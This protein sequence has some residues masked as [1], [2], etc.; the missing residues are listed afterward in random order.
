VEQIW[1]ELFL[2][3]TNG[4]YNDRMDAINLDTNVRQ[5]L[6]W[7]IQTAPE[8][9]A[10]RARLILAYADGMQTC[11][12]AE[13]AGLSRGR[14]RYWK[15]EF[16]QRGMSIFATGSD[17]WGYSPTSDEAGIDRPK[18]EEKIQPDI[19]IAGRTP[20]GEKR[21]KK[22]HSSK[23]E[24]TSEIP[25]LPFPEPLKNPGLQMNDS[26]VAAGKKIFRLQFAEMLLHEEGS[27]SGEDI[28]ALHDM[29]VASRRLR[30]AFDI[31]EQAFKG[32]TV[33]Q[34]LGG[35][36]RAGRLLGDVRDL[37]V[38]MKNA[39]D[40]LN[41]VSP[42]ERQGLAPLLEAWGTQLLDARERLITHF[43]SDDYHHFTLRFNYFIQT[44]EDGI[45]TFHMDAPVPR[46]ICEIVPILIYTRLASVRAYASLVPNATIPQLHTLRIELKKFRYT[47]EFFTEVLGG[48]A[49]QV[50]D[51]IKKLQDHL[52]DLHDADV[53]CQILNAFL[54][55]WDGSQARV[56]VTERKNP[57]SIVNYLAYQYAERHRLL[58]SFPEVW[59][60][61]ETPD[62]MRQVASAV[63]VL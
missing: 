2:T 5:Q 40:Y 55:N 33:K 57:E 16:F 30:A 53:A 61:F 6:R 59:E 7:V 25:E 35:L 8:S 18:P 15:R 36:R 4:G 60:R 56:M 19:H 52:G 39:E 38:F 14:A 48:D 44:P 50:I 22:K 9:I 29:R 62:I 20:T 28:E 42:D 51:L 17:A 32:K 10:R 12:A 37:D 41:S 3:V 63:S 34:H 31:F 13:E 26:L 47:L 45:E 43:D 21:K 54:E 46:L 1:N 27:R 11:T 58:I 23:K 49:W 24:K